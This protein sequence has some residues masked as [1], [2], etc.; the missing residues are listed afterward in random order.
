MSHAK[1]GAKYLFYGLLAGI[2]FAPR[3]GAET[4]R[5][6]RNWTL[7]TLNDPFTRHRS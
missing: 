4:R 3:A 2:L 6:I 5:R 7:D 1:T